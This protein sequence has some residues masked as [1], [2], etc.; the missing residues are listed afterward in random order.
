MGGNEA[1]DNGENYLMQYLPSSVTDCIG[2]DTLDMIKNAGKPIKQ[3]DEPASDNGQMI[4]HWGDDG[5]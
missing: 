1:T 3:I 4:D 2:E 5:G